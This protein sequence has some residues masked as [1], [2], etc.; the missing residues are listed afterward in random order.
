MIEAYWCWISETNIPGVRSP[1]A[2]PISVL[3][4]PSWDSTHPMFMGN[5][6]FKALYRYGCIKTGTLPEQSYLSFLYASSIRACERGILMQVLAHLYHIPEPS[7]AQT[8]SDY[9]QYSLGPMKIP[10]VL[11]IFVNFFKFRSLTSCGCKMPRSRWQTSF[12][13]QRIFL[14]G[15]SCSE[16]PLEMLLGLLFIDGSGGDWLGRGGRQIILLWGWRNGRNRG[17]DWRIFACFLG[18]GKCDHS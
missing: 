5:V 3:M 10:R 17:W 8:Y 1:T 2:C 18:V 13:V 4:G 14:W 12:S 9:C 16:L 11:Y 7:C 15:S 6:N